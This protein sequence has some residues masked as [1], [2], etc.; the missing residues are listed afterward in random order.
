MGKLLAPRCGGAV[1]PQMTYHFTLTLQLSSM[2]VDVNKVLDDSC[3]GGGK[4]GGHGLA[5]VMCMLAKLGSFGAL[6]ELLVDKYGLLCEH[7]TCL[8]PFNCILS[9]QV[10][11][12]VV[13]HVVGELLMLVHRKL[14]R[15]KVD[16]LLLES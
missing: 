9:D 13:V 7:I 10:H 8:Q 5:L 4:V 16:V 6:R 15:T 14:L 3:T 1:G 11:C 2:L 12:G